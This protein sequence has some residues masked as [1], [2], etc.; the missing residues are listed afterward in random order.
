MRPR[1]FCTCSIAPENAKSSKRLE[2]KST[3]AS[4]YS[5]QSGNRL[6]AKTLDAA[7]ERMVNTRSGVKILVS[8]G[9]S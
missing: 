5:L 2:M 1:C 4:L 9:I 7:H 8:F 6:K 3:L